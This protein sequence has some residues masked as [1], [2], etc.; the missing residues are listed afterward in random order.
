MP[1]A[2]EVSPAYMALL[3]S[4]RQELK[5]ESQRL[6]KELAI[7]LSKVFHKMWSGPPFQ[8]TGIVLNEATLLRATVSFWEDI[9]RVKAYHPVEHADEYKKAAYLFKWM[10]KMRP[11]KPLVDHPDIIR[12]QDMNANALFAWLCAQG[13]LKIG[14]LPG[15]EL[16][17][18][19]YSATYR[20]VNPDEWATIFYLLEKT[21]CNAA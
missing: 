10:A 20:E 7:R 8:C 15:Q 18:V 2:Q 14:V 6:G 21:Y 5:I 12:P 1:L 11:V 13:Y 17:R 16:K 4:C 9:L 19:I 3:Q